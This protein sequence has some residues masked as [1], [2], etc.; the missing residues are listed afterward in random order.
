MR[1]AM[2]PIMKPIR[3]RLQQI[4]LRRLPKQIIPF[5]SL[6]RLRGRLSR[7]SMI[8]MSC[9]TV[10]LGAD[11]GR[12]R[13]MSQKIP[14]PN[15]I[16]PSCLISAFLAGLDLLR[17][18]LCQLAVLRCLSEEHNLALLEV[19]SSVLIDQNEREVV[20]RAEFLV[21]IAEGRGEIEAS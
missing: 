16:T 8:M 19:S 2:L 10:V 1:L 4:L 17:L 9:N 14:L 21:D 20:A 13:T 18:S 7:C 3:R 15:A 5:S 11:G 12:R 6:W